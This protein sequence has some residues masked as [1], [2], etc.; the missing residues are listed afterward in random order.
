MAEAVT[1]PGELLR[2]LELPA[3]LLPAARTAARRFSLRVPRGFVQLMEPGN[4]ADP[5]LRQVLPLARELEEHPGFVDDPLDEHQALQGPGVL[6]KYRGRSLL[7]ASPACAIHCR[8]CFRR[9]FPYSENRASWQ[10]WRHSLDLLRADSGV[11]EVILSGGDPLS[12]D[13]G[14]LEELVRGLEDIPH[15]RRLRIHSRLPV[16]I[17]ERITDPLVKLLSNTRLRPILVVHCNHPR[18][19]GDDFTQAMARLR[20]VASLLNQSVL[21]QDVNDDAHS[22]SNLSRQ[23]F[24]RDIL[25]YYIHLMDRVRGAAHFEVSEHKARRL[26]DALRAELPGYLVPRLVREQAGK[27]AK[28]PIT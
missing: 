27:A 15:L 1:D 21:L 18:E 19:L 16:V 3:S 25:P 8:Y 23:L 9:E 11:E 7:I 14:R 12:L 10:H 17:P 13:D 22:L 28:T 5:L 20:P 2:L 6:S 26:M 4:P 24:D